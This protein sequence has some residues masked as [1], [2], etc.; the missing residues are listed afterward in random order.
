MSNI[1]NSIREH[2][3][4][5]TGSVKRADASCVESIIK[6]KTPVIEVASF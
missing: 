4:L 5:E 3:I 2:N 1:V 6:A